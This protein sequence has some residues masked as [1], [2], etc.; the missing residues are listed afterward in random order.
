MRS[1]QKATAPSLNSATAP[2]V[3][4]PIREWYERLAMQYDTMEK[5]RA[6]YFDATKSLDELNETI[7]ALKVFTEQRKQYDTLLDTAVDELLE[8]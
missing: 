3:P 2:P 7:E 6:D 5:I 8:N 4:K 1:G